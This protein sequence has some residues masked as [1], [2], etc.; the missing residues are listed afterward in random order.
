MAEREVPGRGNPEPGGGSAP[1]GQAP[2]SSA[3][4]AALCTTEFKAQRTTNADTGNTAPT[5]LG[6]TKP[7]SDP[8]NN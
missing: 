1:C 7:R 3:P 5:G 4:C 8:A 2:A 6:K